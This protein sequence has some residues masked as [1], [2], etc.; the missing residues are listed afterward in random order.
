MKLYTHNR[1]E[2]CTIAEAADVLDIDPS[3]IRRQIKRDRYGHAF[4][5]RGKRYPMTRVGNLTWVLECPTPAE[6]YPQADTR[7]ARSV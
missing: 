1:V 5:Y 2:V 7:H 6:S 4:T 3:Y